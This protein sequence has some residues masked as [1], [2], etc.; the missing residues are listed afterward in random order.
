MIGYGIVISSIILI[1]I[2]WFFDLNTTGYALFV[3]NNLFMFGYG[4]G[5]GPI[6][7]VYLADILPYFGLSI[8]YAFNYLFAL[9]VGFFYGQGYTYYDKRTFINSSLIIFLI[10]SILGFVF[11]IFYIKETKG[12]S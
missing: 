9:I 11:I 8:S 4:I 5:P 7:F 3:G 10:L 6:V 1:F 12:N 2:F